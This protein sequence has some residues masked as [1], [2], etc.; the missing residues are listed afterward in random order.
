MPMCE[1]PLLGTILYDLRTPGRYRALWLDNKSRPWSPGI[2]AP[3]PESSLKESQNT[4]KL[5]RKFALAACA[6]VIAA[7]PVTAQDAA[8]RV[9]EI[10]TIPAEVSVEVGASTPPSRRRLRRGRK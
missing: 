8:T 10:R 5:I 6:A 7:V 3:V 2:A 9:T 1:I 4:M